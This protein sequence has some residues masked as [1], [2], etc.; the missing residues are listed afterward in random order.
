[1]S[2]NIEIIIHSWSDA[3][4]TKTT[5]VK[6]LLCEGEAAVIVYAPYGCTCSPH[7]IQ[8]R[9]IQ[10]LMRAWDSQENITVI[11]D[12]IIKGVS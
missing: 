10:H 4:E 11:E 7:K 8:P 1:M 9:C 2:D 12:F 6:C 3:P 5:P